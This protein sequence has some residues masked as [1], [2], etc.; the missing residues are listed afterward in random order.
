MEIHATKLVE[1][2]QA[3]QRSPR[4]NEAMAEGHALAS[5]DLWADVHPMLRTLPAT[6]DHSVTFGIMHSTDST[7]LVQEFLE[8]LGET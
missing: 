7:P 3:I 8:A 2:A 5:L 4:C 1:Q 6:W